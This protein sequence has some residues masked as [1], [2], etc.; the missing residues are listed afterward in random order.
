MTDEWR[1]THWRAY[2]M[3]LARGRRWGGEGNRHRQ[4]GGCADHSSS[5]EPYG[6]EQR[7]RVGGCS[8]PCAE[9]M[10]KSGGLNQRGSGSEGKSARRRQFS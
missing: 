3:K 4:A 9:R 2:A 1:Y 6:G 5:S 8:M 7:D 10:E